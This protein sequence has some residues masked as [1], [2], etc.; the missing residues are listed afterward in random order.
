[1]DI[2]PIRTADDYEAALKE[3]ERLFNAEPGTPDSDRLD[4]LVTLVEAYEA[5]HFPIPEPKNPA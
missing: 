3:V 4:I 1:M 5:E 2:K